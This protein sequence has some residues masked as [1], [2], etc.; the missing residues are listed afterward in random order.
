MKILIAIFV[1]LMLPQ[2]SSNAQFIANGNLNI[3]GNFIV[4]ATV[5]AVITYLQDDSGNNISDDSGNLVIGS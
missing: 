2:A 3:K 4:L 1:L 5:I